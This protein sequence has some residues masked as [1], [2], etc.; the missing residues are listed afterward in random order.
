MKNAIFYRPYLCHLPPLQL[1]RKIAK[2]L[3]QCKIN[4]TIRMDEGLMIQDGGL[5]EKV[6]HLYRGRERNSNNQ[7]QNIRLRL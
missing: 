3:S 4:I 7:K 1:W 2:T 6:V 5:N